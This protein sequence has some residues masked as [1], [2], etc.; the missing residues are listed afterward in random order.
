MSKSFK[1]ATLGGGCFWC[2]EAVYKRL[3]GV[4]SVTSG[5]SGGR[6]K[7]PA[8]REVCTGRTGHAEVCDIQYNP[9]QVTFKDILQVFWEVHDPTTLN[10]QG[11]DVGTHYRSVIFV[12]DEEQRITAEKMKA[13]LEKTVFKDPVVT[14]ITD[15]TNFYPAEDYHNDYYDIHTEEPYC[16]I[17]IQPKVEK[18]NRIFTSQLKK[19]AED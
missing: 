16:R 19:K 14:E 6:I 17:V 5:F 18:F 11:N 15:F 4:V 3:N 7:N 2:I 8:Y 12:H 9:E 10:R 13:K 1:N